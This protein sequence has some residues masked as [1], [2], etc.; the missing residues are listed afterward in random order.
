MLAVL[1]FILAA[2][3]HGWMRWMCIANGV[4]SLLAAVFY[5]YRK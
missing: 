2:Q 1:W 5:A 3:L 4:T